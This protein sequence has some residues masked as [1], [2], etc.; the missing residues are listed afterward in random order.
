MLK[1]SFLDTIK[2]GLGVAYI[3]LENAPNREEY[4]ET[5]LYACFIDCSNDF[6]FE[7]SKGFYIYN[8]IS[9]LNDKE[10]F[11]TKII[12][13]LEKKLP[14][15]ALFAQLLDI[16]KCYNFD[17]D[18]NIKPFLNK[19]YK[20]FLSKKKWNKNRLLCFE[21]LCI[22]MYQ[23]FS[24]K[25]VYSILE[26]IENYKINKKSIYWFYSI[27][28]YNHKKNNKIKN[29]M[30]EEHFIK[31]KKTYTYTFSEFLSLSRKN[32]YYPNFPSFA[33]DVEFQKCINYLSTTN[34]KEDIIIILE[35][36]Q[37]NYIK[38]RIPEDLLFS[39]IHKHGKEVDDEIYETLSYQKSKNIEKLGLTLI[40]DK[41]NIV[42]GIMILMRNYKKDY[43]KLLINAFK[44][45][46]FYF[47]TY[48]PLINATIDFMYSSK[49]D[50]PDEILFYIYN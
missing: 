8:L 24:I 50:L 48:N 10:Y 49:K 1:K 20:Q 5:L 47:R 14:K 26:D 31:D 4:R 12:S 22:T 41:E 9:L 46:K 6:T 42:N 35:D 19:Y 16:L 2:K 7:R 27:L 15:R 29:F 11:K 34:N 18:K 30:P 23:I 28:P 37:N 38:R 33:N 3:E 39:L 36:F 21:Y 40:N 32:D 43:K 25:K 44:K 13:Y 45:V 17:G